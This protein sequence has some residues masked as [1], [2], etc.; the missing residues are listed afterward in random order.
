MIEAFGG[1]H[2]IT[3]PTTWIH[4]LA[5]VIGEVRLGARVSIWPGAVL[6]GDQGAIEV[7]DDSNIQDGSV[8]HDTG[9]RSV[10]RVGA[11]VTVGH[12]AILHGC[13]VGDGC[14]I[15]MG[16]IVLDNAEIGEGSIVGAG[17]LVTAGTRIPP[18]S[19]VLG[20][21]ARVARPVTDEQRRW[22]EHS[23]RTYVGLCEARLSAGRGGADGPNGALPR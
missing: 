10:T 18:G 17:A 11:W 22:I 13:V 1:H 16:A 19:L 21:P 6:R 14:L 23:W 8:L 3:T 9:G 2:P 12:R 4:P 7:G 5:C 20:S 15:G